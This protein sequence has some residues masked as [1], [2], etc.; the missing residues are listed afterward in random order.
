MDVLHGFHGICPILALGIDPLDDFFA[1]S[2]F[3]IFLALASASNWT[4]VVSDWESDVARVACTGR[5]GKSRAKT[6]EEGEGGKA[7]D[8]GY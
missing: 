4:Y 2:D 1:I 5:V 3:G 7:C 8:L 6:Q